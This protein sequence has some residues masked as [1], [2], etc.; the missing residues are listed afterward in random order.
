MHK[1]SGFS[2]VELSVATAVT[3]FIFLAAFTA[4][5]HFHHVNASIQRSE[6]IHSNVRLGMDKLERE[7]RVSGFGVPRDAQ[8]GASTL[9][10]PA[11]FHAT[12]TEVGFRAEIDGASGEAVEIDDAQLS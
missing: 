10:T 9:W 5:S 8:I 1:T 2:L 12:S 3:L 7:L 11:I 4:Y 6:K